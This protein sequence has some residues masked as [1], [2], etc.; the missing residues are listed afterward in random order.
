[1]SL[2]QDGSPA[3]FDAEDALGMSALMKSYTAGL[4]KYARDYMVFLA[5]YINSYKR[6]VAGT[7][8]PTR[9][10]W[11]V[12]NRTAG[13]RLCGDGT[14]GIRIECRVGGSDLNPY[15]AMAAL[16]AA[17]LKGVEEDLALQPAFSGDAYAGEAPELPTTLPAARE[18]LLA[19]EMLREAFGEE[20]VIHYARAAE[21]EIEDHNRVVTDY[22]IAR[23]FEMA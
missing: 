7:F 9:I 3:F 5:P 23:G 15:T 18:A 10:I 17:G 21:V 11:S 20:V 13:F 8:A 14:K 1:M 16:L 6:F 2:W 12:D 19:S 4:L 22:E